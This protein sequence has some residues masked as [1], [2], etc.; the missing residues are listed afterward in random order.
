MLPYLE[1]LIKQNIG[2]L[3]E[4]M[5]RGVGQFQLFWAFDFCQYFP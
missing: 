2:H 5:E 4:E 3:D 1:Y